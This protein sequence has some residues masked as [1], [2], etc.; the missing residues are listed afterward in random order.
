MKPPCPIRSRS[1]RATP[2]IRPSSTITRF[3][4][5]IRWLRG[6]PASVYDPPRSP[7]NIFDLGLVYTIDINPENEVRVDH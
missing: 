4:P 5:T 1:W 2:P 6:L 3:T 7:V